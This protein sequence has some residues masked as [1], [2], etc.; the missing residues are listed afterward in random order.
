MADCQILDLKPLRKGCKVYK[1]QNNFTT[2]LKREL[3]KKNEQKEYKLAQLAGFLRTT[4]Q[5]VTEK[6]QFGFKFMTESE[7]IAEHFLTSIEDNFALQLQ[8]IE[9]S[10]DKRNGRERLIFQTLSQKGLQMLQS[11]SVI[12]YNGTLP[13]DNFN[14]PKK[15]L[16]NNNSVKGYIAGAFLGNGSCSL[17]MAKN[18]GYHLEF[19][20]YNQN[21]ADAFMDL[22]LECNILTKQVKRKNRIVVYLKSRESICDFL[23]FLEVDNAL[24]KFDEIAQIRDTNNQI[25]RWTNCKL[26]NMDR[27]ITASIRQVQAIEK[28]E[29]SIG[30]HSLEPPLLEVATARVKE[31]NCSMQELADRLNITKS[32]LNHRIRKLL[33]LA[34]KI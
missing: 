8:V 28:I 11:L 14:I 32:C 33:Q 30:L 22:L 17:P 5:I 3:I 19:V 20:F 10:I 26:G 27:T 34:K 15:I 6:G 13:Q 24:K 16:Q 31:P 1:I 2:E 7:L 12:T 18:N 29:Q 4:A 23:A 25:N 9:A 21:F